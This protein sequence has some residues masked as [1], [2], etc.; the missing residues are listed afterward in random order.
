MGDQTQ[1]YDIFQTPLSSGY[2]LPLR[3]L[4]PPLY[5]KT[6]ID[7]MAS[8]T[9]SWPFHILMASTTNSNSLYWLS[10]NLALHILYWLSHGL[11]TVTSMASTTLSKQLYDVLVVSTSSLLPLQQSQGLHCHSHDV[12]K[13]SHGLFKHSTLVL[14]YFSRLLHTLTLSILTSTVTL[15]ASICTFSGL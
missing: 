7:I 2:P 14:Y 3:N 11:Y 10:Q 4:S 9:L 8:S 1:A 13:H 12:Y 15:A 6:N 5:F